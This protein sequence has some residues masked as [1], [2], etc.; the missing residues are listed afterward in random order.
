MKLPNIDPNL[1]GTTTRGYTTPTGEVFLQP[2]LSRAE[3]ASTLRHEGVHVY[4]T[5]KGSGPIAT[6]RQNLGQ[7]GYDNSALLQ[8]VEEFIAESHATGSLRQGW[9][10]AFSGAY[11]TPLYRVTPLTAGAELTV[12]IGG[13][14]AAGYGGYK[15]GQSIFGDK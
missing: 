15:I 2:G 13:V 6:V 10:H 5:P 7:A 8:G 12:Y 3:Q 4:F 14:A 1:A 9:A 11:D